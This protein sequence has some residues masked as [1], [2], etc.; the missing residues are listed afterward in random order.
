M[1]AIG[2]YDVLLAK[3]SCGNDTRQQGRADRICG[4]TEE[5]GLPL[6]FEMSEVVEPR[7]ASH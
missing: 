5:E 4:S 1:A 2:P 3:G 7:K 6:G